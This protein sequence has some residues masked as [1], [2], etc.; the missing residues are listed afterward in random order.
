MLNPDTLVMFSGGIDSTGM[1]WKLL[2]E[3]KALHVHHMNLRNE[4]RR[5]FAEHKSVENILQLM[6]K[7]HEFNYSESTHQ[8]PSYNNKFIW[9]SD[10]VSFIAGTICLSI[11]SIKFVAIGMTATDLSNPDLS[12]RI[13]RSNNV[14]KA[15]TEATKIYPVKNMTKLQIYNMLPVEIRNLTW[16]C[17][18]PIYVNNFAYRCNKCMTCIELMKVETH[19]KLN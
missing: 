18:T 16:S 7:N 13:V 8:Y 15:F 10:I 17:R 5:A 3:K 12:N 4:E 11:P 9:D 6:S 14:F 1:L 2:N 19:D